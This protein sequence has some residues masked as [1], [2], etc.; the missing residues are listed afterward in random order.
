MKKD[1]DDFVKAVTTN[2]EKAKNDRALSNLGDKLEVLGEKATRVGTGAARA[3]KKGL[4][5]LGIPSQF[6]G[7]ADLLND[8]SQVMLPRFIK[9]LKS[10]PLP[11]IE[12][13][14]PDFDIAIDNIL[15]ESASFLPDLTRFE[16]HLDFTCKRGY[17]AFA[18]TFSNSTIIHISL[19]HDWLPMT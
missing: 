7:I 19:V 15:F 16:N 14:S 5:G 2:F 12:Y 13:T 9:V 8:I 11:R 17:A 10:V 4:G 1:I 18:S 3:G 6:G